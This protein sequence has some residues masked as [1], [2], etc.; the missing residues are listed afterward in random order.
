[1]LVV[2]ADQHMHFVRVDCMAGVDVRGSPPEPHRLGALIRDRRD[3][4]LAK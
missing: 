2:P 3:E 4:I 1:L